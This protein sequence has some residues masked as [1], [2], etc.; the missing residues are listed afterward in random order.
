MLSIG[1]PNQKYSRSGRGIALRMLDAGILA[2][3]GPYVFL[4]SSIDE[5]GC[6]PVDLGVGECSGSVE[7]SQVSGHHPRCVIEGQITQSV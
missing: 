4:Y 6:R 7:R 3:R 1:S 5:Q 2:Q